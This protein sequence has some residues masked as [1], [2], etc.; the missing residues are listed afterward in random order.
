MFYDDFETTNPLGSKKGI[1]KLCGIYFTLRNFTPQFNSSLTNIHLCALFHA[2]DIKT[3]GFDA[4]LEPIVNDIKVL[5]NK[6]IQG[7]DGFV[8]GSIVQVTGDNLGLHSLFGFVE[9]FRARYNCRFCL[10][11]REDYQTVFCEDEPNI[12]FRTKE[13][14]FSTQLCRYNE[15]FSRYNEIFSR[16]NEIF[17]R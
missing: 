6:G 16:Y 4:I 13:T 15:I 7:P 12:T 10:A 17:S 9:S 5:E 8:R 3:Y 2:Q 1:H 14:I 11:E